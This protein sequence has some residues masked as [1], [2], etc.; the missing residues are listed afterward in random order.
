MCM[1]FVMLQAAFDELGE[2]EMEAKVGCIQLI[3]GYLLLMMQMS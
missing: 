3:E 2:L 1:V